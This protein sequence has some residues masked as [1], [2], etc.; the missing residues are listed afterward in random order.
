MQ[1]RLFNWNLICTELD[2]IG[3]IV[4]NDKKSMYVAGDSQE[5]DKLFKRIERYVT[6]I[7]SDS[8]ILNFENYRREDTG[9]RNL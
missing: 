5:I 8:G 7:S 6:R 3:I 1:T 2:K 4:E 9:P